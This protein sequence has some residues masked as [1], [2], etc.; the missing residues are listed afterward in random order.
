MMHVSEQTQIIF[1][2]DETMENLALVSL[3]LLCYILFAFV[4]CWHVQVQQPVKSLVSLNKNPLE[5][6]FQI[7]CLVIPISDIL[8]DPL[9]GTFR[10][11]KGTLSLGSLHSMRDISDT[12]FSYWKLS[13]F[14]NT[15]LCNTVRIFFLLCH[16]A[17]KTKQK[18][19]ISSNEIFD[20]CT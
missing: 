8:V 15:R 16:H 10:Y 4:T 12:C 6:C 11:L 19:S 14:L 5:N 3:A 13:L 2:L 17:L 1:F 7:M 9:S 20:K 18:L